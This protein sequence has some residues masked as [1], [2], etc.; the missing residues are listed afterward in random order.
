MKWPNRLIS[1]NAWPILSGVLRWTA[2]A[3]PQQAWSRENDFWNSPPEPLTLSPM[4][5]KVPTCS[6]MAPRWQKR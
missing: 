5:T 3:R 6:W 1:A 4:K 2:M